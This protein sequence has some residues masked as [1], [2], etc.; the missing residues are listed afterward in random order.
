MKGEKTNKPVNKNLYLARSSFRTEG[1]I[2]SFSDK[3]K[4]KEFINTKLVLQ[5]VLKGFKWKKNRP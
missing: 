2:K 4:L 1:D 5:E 3:E